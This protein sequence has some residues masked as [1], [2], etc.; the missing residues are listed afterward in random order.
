MKVP[1]VCTLWSH[2]PPKPTPP[3]L[4]SAQLRLPRYAHISA[5]CE[6]RGEW[7]KGN[8]RFTS[9]K[10]SDHFTSTWFWL[11]FQFD[12]FPV[13]WGS[14][15][16]CAPGRKSR[17]GVLPQCRSSPITC[18][19]INSIRTGLC[20][21][22]ASVINQRC[23]KERPAPLLFSFIFFGSRHIPSYCVCIY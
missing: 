16:F 3:A 11:S 2:C 14:S 18:A 12:F 4:L 7:R 8:L 21:P 19:A 22:D 10:S 17:L 6:G 5:L 23:L 9:H 20:M 13:R 15:C 1:F